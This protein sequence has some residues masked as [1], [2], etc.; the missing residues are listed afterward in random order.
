MNRKQKEVIVNQVLDSFNKSKGLFIIDLKKINATQAV[1][2]KKQLFNSNSKLVVVKNSLLD[3]AAKKNLILG[4]LSSYFKDQIA[5]I[6]AFEDIMKTATVVSSFLKNI[7][8]V[9]FKVGLANKVIHKDRFE[10][11]AKMNS[12]SNLYAVL[13]GGLKAPI[14]NLVFVLKQISEKINQ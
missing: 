11:L 12:Q 6:Y 3:L 13:C 1:L 2:L 10:K 7:E 5:L 14:V 9:N 8:E 4:Q